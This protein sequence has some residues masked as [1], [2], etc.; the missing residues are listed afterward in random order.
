M[1]WPGRHNYQLN[2]EIVLR[3][4]Y[5]LVSIV[6]GDPGLASLGMA[7]DPLWQLRERFIEDEL[8]HTLV[9]I[10]IANRIH[11]EHMQGPRDDEDEL[12]FRPISQQCGSLQPNI[13]QQRQIPL[14]FKEAC[15]KIIHAENIV[16]QTEGA[17]ESNPIGPYLT[18]RGTK[19]GKVWVA[20]L[21]LLDYARAS[22]QNFDGV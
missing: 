10:A 2:S 19:N 9:S 7:H 12:S 3:D 18:L 20:H 22:V 8:V 13:D 5:R 21:D 15:H 11:L 14:S 1:S 17:P 4:L 16:A 6:V